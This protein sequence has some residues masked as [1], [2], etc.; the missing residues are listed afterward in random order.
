MYVLPKEPVKLH[1]AC[2]CRWPTWLQSMEWWSERAGFWQVINVY[3]YQENGCQGLHCSLKKCFSSLNKREVTAFSIIPKVI[4]QLLCLPVSLL[5]VGLEWHILSP[6]FHFLLKR[7]GIIGKISISM[8]CVRKS[9]IIFLRMLRKLK[10]TNY[11]ITIISSNRVA[12]EDTK[13]E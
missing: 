5:V 12:V 3:R 10:C 6:N 13:N 9:G 11:L 1:G 8:D 2:I 4:G 7:L